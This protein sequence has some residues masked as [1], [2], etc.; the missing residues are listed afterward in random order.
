MSSLLLAVLVSLLS[1]GFGFL[2]GFSDSSAVFNFASLLSSSCVDFSTSTG[3]C[4]DISSVIRSM[5]LVSASLCSSASLL[6]VRISY[7]LNA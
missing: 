6:R 7:F 5:R 4:W 2:R 1:V 3:G